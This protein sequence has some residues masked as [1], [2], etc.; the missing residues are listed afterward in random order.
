MS[1]RSVLRL[2]IG[3]LK[4]KGVECVI[5]G[6]DVLELV[7]GIKI[8][9]LDDIDLFVTNMSTLLEEQLF[10]G[11]AKENNWYYSTT[12]LDTPKYIIPYGGREYHV[13]LY[14]NIY[15]FYIP[16]EL[17]DLS[18][19]VKLNGKVTCRSLN[20]E[21]YLI[22]KAKAG[23]EKDNEDLKRI[24][25]LISRGRLRINKT[26]LREYLTYVPEEEKS[27]VRNKLIKYKLL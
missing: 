26:T 6:S 1:R 24:S 25:E 10:R 21:A 13:E 22:L 19:K 2:V 4:D 16:P 15:D 12:W 14:E 18:V 23:R 20:V 17:L 11:I 7:G 5:I 27:M 9:E 8:S 3:K